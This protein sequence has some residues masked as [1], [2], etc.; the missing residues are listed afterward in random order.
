[1]SEK[2][3]LDSSDVLKYYTAKLPLKQMPPYQRYKGM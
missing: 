1:M 3:S 2:I